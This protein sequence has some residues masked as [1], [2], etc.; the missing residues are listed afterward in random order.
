MFCFVLFGFQLV[1]IMALVGFNSSHNLCVLFAWKTLF[2]LVCCVCFFFI[3]NLSFCLSNG[4]HAICVPFFRF[5]NLRRL[6][7]IANIIALFSV[8]FY[9]NVFLLFAVDAR[10]DFVFLFCFFFEC[11]NLT[12]PMEKKKRHVCICCAHETGVKW[13]KKRKMHTKATINKFVL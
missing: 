2:I 9:R 5:T 13:Q 6:H 4:M 11:V 8:P 1:A 7:S 10:V 3:F 12:E